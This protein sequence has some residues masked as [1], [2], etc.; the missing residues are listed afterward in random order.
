M[1]DDFFVDLTEKLCLLPGDYEIIG[2]IYDTISKEHSLRR[3]RLHVAELHKDPLPDS[4]R[5]LPSVQGETQCADARLYLPLKSRQPFRIE[6][7]VNNPYMLGTNVLPR[8]RLLSELATA[9]ALVEITAIDMNARLSRGREVQ[10]E[11]KLDQ[12]LWA[13][14]PQSTQNEVDVR[15]LEVDRGSAKFF[16][17]QIPERLAASG[18][19][20]RAIVILSEPRK[21]PKEDYPETV[22]SELPQGTH[23]FYLRCNPPTV[24]WH[25]IRGRGNLADGN[26][27]GSD[28]IPSAPPRSTH[29]NDTLER[30]LSPLHPRLFDVTTSLDFRRALAAILNDVN[31]NNR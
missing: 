26:I 2:A 6:V 16:V 13:G 17:S 18:P 1:S 29:V 7:I 23:V 14:F 8:L 25:P 9:N 27:F 4:W 3:Q 15:A 19:P 12:S 31:R 5:G 22:P 30:V 28:P 11:S 21:L 24:F 20:V 10:I